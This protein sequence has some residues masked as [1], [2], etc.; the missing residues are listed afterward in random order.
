MPAFSGSF[1]LYWRSDTRDVILGMTR[2]TNSG[3]IA[4]AV[5]ETTACQT[6]GVLDAMNKDSGVVL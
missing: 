3:H 1:A 5:L 4:R 2:F 6:R